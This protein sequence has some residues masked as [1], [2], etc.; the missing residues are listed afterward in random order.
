MKWVLRILLWLVLLVTLPIG[1]VLLLEPEF[2]LGAQR[3][4][5]ARLL[6]T[7]SGREVRLDGAVRVRLGRHARVHVG[8][9]AI[10]NPDWAAQAELFSAR[11][12]ALGIDLA[13]LLSGAW[14]LEDIRLR[15]A[16]IALEVSPEGQ[17]SWVFAQPGDMTHAATPDDAPGA[18][19]PALRIEEA[20][21]ENVGLTYQGDGA[22]HRLQLDHFSQRS[23]RGMLLLDGTGA[24]DGMALHIVGRIG[25]LDALLRGQGIQTDL[26]VSLDDT[27]L[28]TQGL[29]GDLHQFEDISL[30]TTLRGPSLD[31]VLN[32]LGIA[33]GQAGD[34]DARLV[35]RDEEPGLSWVADGRL[36]ALRLDARGALRDPDRLDGLAATLDVQGEDLA[37]LAHVLGL[38]GLP[39]QAYSATG[40]ITREGDRL[41]VRGFEL[42]S[43]GDSAAL[44]AVLPHF[45][46]L[47]GADA[48]LT[49]NLA[50][51]SRYGLIRQQLQVEGPLQVQAELA[52]ATQDATQ[53][54]ASGSWG[55]HALELQGQFGRYPALADSRVR[56]RFA[57]PRIPT[58]NTLRLPPRP[59]RLAGSL[60]VDAQRRLMLELDE[61][62]LGD[63]QLAASGSLG[64]W[65][66]LED[67]DL[68]VSAEG[69]SLRGFTDHFTEA[70]LP[71]LP[72][73]V[74]T[75]LRGRLSTPE[76]LDTGAALGDATLQTMGTL[77]LA[78]GL[79]G[80]DVRVDLKVPDLASL[81]PGEL[82]PN[83]GHD[84]YRAVGRVRHADGRLR[85]D[86]IAIT[87]DKLQAR[88]S[89]TLPGDLALVG[90]HLEL[91]ALA[92]DLG[93]LLPPSLPYTAPPAPLKI[94][95][96]LASRQQ[97]LEIRALQLE[98][99]DA[100]LLG[101]GTLRQGDRGLE[102]TI[103]IRS[104]IP[105][106]AAVG[107]LDGVGLPEQP[108][109][110]TATL[111]RAGARTS[112]EALSATLGQGEISGTLVY[113]ERKRPHV[114]LDL[115]TRGIDLRQI[116]AVAAPTPPAADPRQDQPQQAD[117]PAAGETPPSE[118]PAA[119]RFIPDTPIELPLLD[120][121]DGR[122]RLRG[123]GMFVP[124]PRFTGKA[125]VR[126]HVV[127]ATLQDGRLHV[128][129]LQ[130]AG[131]RGELNGSGR[132]ATSADGID[133]S[134]Q[135]TAS[136]FHF[137]ILATGEGLDELPAHDASLD[138][139]SRGR[140][141]RD[142][143]A[144]LNGSARLSG[145]GGLT[146]NTGLDRAMR[147]FVAELISNLNPFSKR[148]KRSQIDCTAAALAIEDGIVQL[149]PGIVVRTDK[150]DIAASGTIDLRSEQIDVQFHSVPRK[151]LGI[152]AAGAVQ[153]FIKVGGTLARPGI[154]LDAPKAL[155]SG[156]AAVATGGISILA[157][158][159]LDRLS[160]VTNPCKALLEQADV[161]GP[162]TTI[163][164]LDAIGDA[165]RGR[166]GRTPPPD[167]SPEE[168]SVLDLVD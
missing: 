16:R 28:R 3:V 37:A 66:A 162:P 140:T 110:L 124:D 26:S 56:F 111:K 81:V 151:G 139:A 126:S 25:T 107:T 50:Q 156:T 116:Q 8:D 67:A 78:R 142:L 96:A 22:G 65:P 100:R 157:S 131:D 128:E 134:W 87:G 122:L 76:L 163:N 58:A 159:L 143:A 21:L 136:N 99:A 145:G 77:R 158:S 13:G 42:H 63:M 108:L 40:E 70:A 73:R 75:R 147:S 38:P 84:S 97:A 148:E 11:E 27:V 127:D 123:E 146:N 133:T 17:R 98:L 48:T 69:P 15:D 80:S 115:V 35:V 152:S 130:L 144:A 102:G 45:P 64:A 85:L 1:A 4:H 160:T 141:L 72:Y 129:H 23:D 165:V 30:E 44:D 34:I 114:D 31:H 112:I 24:L 61:G 90:S 46:T 36:G 155:V 60:A 92:P 135:I 9:V 109:Q 103:N 118:Q 10:A 168:G 104:D 88:L 121:V 57:G 51:P 68:A 39:N 132:L 137:G 119:D 95:L 41:E 20:L 86:D 59:Y 125:I 62:T 101:D 2:D 167:A 89:G 91:D 113:E 54:K 150:I 93:S 12:A 29:L 105:R 106:L 33:Y 19:G 5:L 43:A 153:P 18:R 32:A 47:D 6:T 117:T 55:R 164:P 52:A 94:K 83:W 82:P 138:L 53:I 71:D 166:R 74:Q 49:L 79:A 14:H 7:A 161:G 154:E 149:F 120:T